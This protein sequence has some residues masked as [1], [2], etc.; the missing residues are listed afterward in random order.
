MCWA[1]LI[2]VVEATEVTGRTVFTGND[3]RAARQPVLP[4]SF[5][6]PPGRGAGRRGHGQ[7]AGSR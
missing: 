6:G 4:P 7:G 5:P 2:L 3:V 1:Q